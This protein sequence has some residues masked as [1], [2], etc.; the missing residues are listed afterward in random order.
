MKCIMID[1]VTMHVQMM[2][3]NISNVENISEDVL[4]M[5][6]IYMKLMIGKCS[7]IENH[8]PSYPM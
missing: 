5:Y 8:F 3:N 1:P 7:D 6:K 4:Q 2:D